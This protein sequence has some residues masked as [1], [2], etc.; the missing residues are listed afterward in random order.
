MGVDRRKIHRLV[1]EIP[2]GDLR[3][4]AVREARE[5]VERGE[6]LSAERARKLL[7]L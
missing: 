6:V 2:D 3:E 7:G 4:E 1:D 5:A